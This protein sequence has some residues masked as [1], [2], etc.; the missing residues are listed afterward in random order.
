MLG[1]EYINNL[2]KPNFKFRQSKITIKETPTL[3]LGLTPVMTVTQVC[4]FVNL[5]RE[6]TVPPYFCATCFH[7]EIG[8]NLPRR[9]YPAIRVSDTFILERLWK[10]SDKCQNATQGT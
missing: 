8:E 4:I 5:C 3:K 9:K 1:H 2:P 10:C 6:T 7:G